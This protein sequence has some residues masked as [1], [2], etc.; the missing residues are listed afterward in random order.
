MSG[1]FLVLV[2]GIV[3][4]SVVNAVSMSIFERSAEIGMMRSVGFLPQQIANIFVREACILTLFSIAAGFVISTITSYI[5]NSLNIR[6][7]PPGI[8]GNMQFVLTPT[9]SLFVFVSLSI[10]LIAAL[11]AY[12]VSRKRA[13]KEIIDLLAS[14]PA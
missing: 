11:A 5:V 9:L 10:G 7:N 8:A 2:F 1:F 6:F 4:V 12:F 3:L 14:K 13:N